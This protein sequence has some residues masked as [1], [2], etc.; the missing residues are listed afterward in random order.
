MTA[1]AAKRGARHTLPESCPGF[2]AHVLLKRDLAPATKIS[3]TTN[4]L[5]YNLQILFHGQVPHS[6]AGYLTSILIFTLHFR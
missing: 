5:F 2:A 3:S 4:T 6:L 1:A